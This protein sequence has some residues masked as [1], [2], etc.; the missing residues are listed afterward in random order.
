[1]GAGR[2]TAGPGLA[3]IAV[4][5]AAGCG[6]SPRELGSRLSQV[7]DSNGRVGGMLVEIEGIVP[8]PAVIEPRLV[9]V[10][11]DGRALTA[12]FHGGD[13]HCQAVAGVDVERRDPEIPRVTIRYGMRLWI[14]SCNAALASLAIRVPMD[15]PFAP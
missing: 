8:A 1:M 13:P 9:E 5:L 11:P 3:L 4:L 12:F 10:D 7:E 2:L 6:G 15:P 14:T